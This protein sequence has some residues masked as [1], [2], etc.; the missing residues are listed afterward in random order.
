M[1]PKR[2]TRTD[3]LRVIGR[4]QHLVGTAQAVNHDRNPNSKAQSDAAL[5]TAHNLC[6]EA[7]AFDPPNASENT[8]RGWG[9][10]GGDD[11]WKNKR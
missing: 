3:L 6:I 4:L 9:D 5:R 7:T 8:G 1:A 11:V 10:A 2:P